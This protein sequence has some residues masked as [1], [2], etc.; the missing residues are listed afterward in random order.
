MK[1]ILTPQE[2]EEYFHNALCNGLYY[3]DG[4][5]LEMDYK[6]EDYKSAKKKLQTP[7]YEDVLMQILRDG[8]QLTMIDVEGDGDQTKS[9]TLAD[10]HQ[11]V[12]ETPLRH[13][14]AMIEENDDA[15]T[16]DAIIQQVFFQ[17]IIFG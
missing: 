2:S 6:E 15:E 12:Q 17:E 14:M 9:I 8:N 16:G 13:L 10:V 5:G 4:Y 11:R 3:I 7:C 1:I